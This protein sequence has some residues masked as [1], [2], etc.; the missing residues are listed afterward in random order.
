MKL[1]VTGA[2]GFIGSHVSLALAA[3]GD[4]VIGIDNIN[5]YYDTSLKYARLDWIAE[6]SANSTSRGNFSFQQIDISDQAAIDQLFTQENFDKVIHLAAQAG[7]RYSLEAPRAYIDSN[8]VGYTNILEACRQ[9]QSLT[10]S[11]IERI[12]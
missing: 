4:E 7:V 5:D 11:L 10:P 1:L 2:A 3:R 8:I 9:N 12:L 6:A